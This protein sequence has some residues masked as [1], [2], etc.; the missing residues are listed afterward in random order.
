MSC[1]PESKL[2]REAELAYTMICMSTDYD[3]WKADEAAVT[4]ETV[5]G[6]MRAN[7]DTANALVAAVLGELVRDEHR[8]V[9]M[10]GHL[11]G[12]SRWAVCT[13]EGAER[14]GEARERLEWLWG[15]GG[16]GEGEVGGEEEVKN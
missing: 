6:N 1:L 10:A 12:G 4:V 8:G 11:K 5:M 16:K 7:S 2:A 9:V 3:C 13:K 15:E 14:G